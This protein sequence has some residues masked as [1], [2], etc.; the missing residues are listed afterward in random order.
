MDEKIQKF[1]EEAELGLDAKTYNVMVKDATSLDTR[2]FID[3]YLPL[4]QKDKGLALAAK[5]LGLDK[6]S[7]DKWTR[8]SES[9][10]SSDKEN[11][12][13]KDAAWLKATW[14]TEFPDIDY[15]TFI[16]DVN[17]MAKHWEDEVK[18]RHEK[19]GKKRRTK[20][21]ENEWPWYKKMLA[22]EYS[23]ARY[24]D[25]PNS[26]PF[27]KEG[28]FDP[29]NNKLELANIG[30][31]GASLVG[32]AIPGGWGYAAGPGVRL[33]NDV[34]QEAGDYGKSLSDIAKDRGMDVAASYIGEAGPNVL[35][36][37][38]GRGVRHGKSLARAAEEI[39][40]YA[41]LMD[42]VDK[43][44]KL[45]KAWQNEP[46]FQRRQKILAEMPDNYVTRS[47]KEYD[48]PALLPNDRKTFT[49]PKL[50]LP[51][52]QNAAMRAAYDD[53]IIDYALKN[54]QEPPVRSV[55]YDWLKKVGATPEPGPKGKAVARAINSPVVEGTKVLVG[56]DLS[57]AGG[58]Q[59]YN[60]RPENEN[61]RKVKDWYKK[62]YSRMWDA[63]F[64]PK[65]DSGLLY[66][67]WKEY[68][69]IE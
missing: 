19:A 67:A 20:E 69:G 26:T 40:D 29:W 12:F 21:V 43:T 18:S 64:R 42:E 51:S 22:N 24:I 44:N 2:G 11:P 27:G 61:D 38:I 41:K 57:K 16:R 68:K 25:D 10:G 46:N 35:L 45:A 60:E 54:K 58:K 14:Q 6:Y 17:S 31:Q 23:Q 9:F 47:L 49:L 36:R 1:L 39:S 56:R 15:E 32:D 53:E 63:N 8:Y 5:S 3:K 34:V 7:K 13:K 66:E 30:L 59:V 28:S 4:I 55:D 62:Q 48:N 37:G 50:E 52:A 33:V 65:E